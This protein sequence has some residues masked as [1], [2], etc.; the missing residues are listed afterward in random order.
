MKMEESKPIYKILLPA[1]VR[2]LSTIA[3]RADPFSFPVSVC[4]IILGC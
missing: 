2:A 1:A 3:E 4:E